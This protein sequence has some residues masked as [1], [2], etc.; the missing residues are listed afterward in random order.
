MTWYCLVLWYYRRDAICSLCIKMNGA[1]KSFLAQ[2][3]TAK[4]W[5]DVFRD[6]TSGSF[7][8]HCK[9]T[10]ANWQQVKDLERK[11]LRKDWTSAGVIIHEEWERQR[12]LSPWRTAQ[13][14]HSNLLCT[15]MINMKVV[16]GLLSDYLYRRTQTVR[17]AKPWNGLPARTKDL[18]VEGSKNRLKVTWEIWLQD[19]KMN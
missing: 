10:K 14:Q 15:C 5:V 12:S 8:T 6:C 18:S 2:V 11:L 4:T 13:K 9:K 17:R 3:R 1:C 7:W 16:I 19:R